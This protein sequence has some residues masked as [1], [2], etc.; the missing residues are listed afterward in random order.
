MGHTEPEMQPAG[1][2]LGPSEAL[3]LPLSPSAS[4]PPCRWRPLL[5]PAQHPPAVLAPPHH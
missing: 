3:P 4:Q 1:L 2:D 5:T